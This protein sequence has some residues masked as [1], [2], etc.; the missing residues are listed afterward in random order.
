MDKLNQ[1]IDLGD[2]HLVTEEESIQSIVHYEK[3]HTD[4][5]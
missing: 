3:A 2:K 5:D 4:L 1:A